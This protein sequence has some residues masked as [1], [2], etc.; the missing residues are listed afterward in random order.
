MR[1]RLRYIVARWSYSTAIFS[2]MFWNEV[3]S[4]NGYTPAAVGAWHREMAQYLLALD[5]N[6][7]LI[8]SNY[9]NLDGQ[10][11]VDDLPGIDLVATNLYTRHDS[12]SSALW[13]ARF[14]TARRAKPYLLTEFGLGHY[15]RWKQND[16]TG[17]ALHDG[18][19]GCA[20]GGAAG[21]AMVWEWDDWVAPC[22]LYHLY[23]PFASVMKDVPFSRYTWKPVA[24][25]TLLFKDPGHPS[26]FASVFFEGFS[27]NYAFNTCPKPRTNV[28]TVT[29]EGT[30]D[31][32]ECFNGALAPSGTRTGA[33]GAAARADAAVATRDSAC[34]FLITMP[35]DGELILHVPR[36]SGE[37]HPI[38][39]ATVD[40]KIV[41]HRELA[42][43]DPNATWDYFGRFPI[44]LS[45]GPHRVTVQNVKPATADNFWPDRVTVAYELTNYL[46]R[47]GPDLN[48]TGLQSNACILLWLR[49]P[50]STWLFARENRPLT[51]Q[52]E[53]RLPLTGISDGDYLVTWTDTFT[54]DVLRRDSIAVHDGKVTLTT[55]PI[56]RSAVAK[57]LRLGR[58]SAP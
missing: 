41:L 45:A 57:L 30:V 4:C 47:N 26:Y 53:G 22:D 37:Q 28:F 12:A 49:N 42:R 7:H 25:G 32:P 35:R 46:E 8:N 39:E 33:G 58:A 52:P 5:P 1:N 36:L 38:L 16:P 3:D 9:G 10:K 48:F 29:P 19:W 31:R 54:G 13:A 56:A 55:P 51:T 24:S 2:W 15:D 21:G 11:E 40:G 14:M 18:L 43:D 34:T 50:A 27:T 17:L 44:P 20:F 23:A 6:R